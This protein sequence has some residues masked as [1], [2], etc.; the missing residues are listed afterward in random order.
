MIVLFNSWIDK[1]DIVIQNELYFRTICL[2]QKQNKI[3]KFICT[4]M[5]QT[6]ILKVK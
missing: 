1:K 6:L 4:I 3:C 2:K 5:E